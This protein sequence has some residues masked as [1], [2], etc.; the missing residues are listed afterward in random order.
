M[1]I[2][3]IKFAMNMFHGINDMKELY[4]IEKE[5]TLHGYY[6][7]TITKTVLGQVFL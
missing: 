2:R 7:V 4:H 3:N 1:E 6:D 5:D